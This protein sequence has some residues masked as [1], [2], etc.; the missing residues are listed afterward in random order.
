MRILMVESDPADA[1]RARECLAAGD[2]PQFAL[3]HVETVERALRRLERTAFDSL[4]VGVNRPGPLDL[5]MPGQIHR[6]APRL[7]IVVLSGLDDESLAIRAVQAGAQD[8]LYKPEISARLLRRTIQ[9]SVIR[10]ELEQR[11]TRAVL[12][13]EVTGLPTRT[14][15]YDRWS[16]S[17]VRARERQG[18]VA[19]LVI[20][21]AGLSDIVEMLGAEAHRS[22]VKTLSQRLGT[23]I[24]LDDTVARIDADHFVILL[25][26]VASLE[27]AE[28]FA[29]RILPL[30]DQRFPIEGEEVT[31]DA[32]I[33]IGFNRGEADDDLDDLLKRTGVTLLQESVSGRNGGGGKGILWA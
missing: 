7:P 11:A 5:E 4:L 23:A 32:R 21:V 10:K 20:E 26:H 31:V 3:D 25:E 12:Y 24:G 8:Y 22:L 16:R 9:H 6:V 15:L 13:D 19:V 1:V 27:Q 18:W 14:L 28:A 29:E 33:S 30:F 2:Q 17:L